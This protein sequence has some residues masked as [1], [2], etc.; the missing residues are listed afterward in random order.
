MLGLLLLIGFIIK[1]FWWIVGAATLVALFFLGRAIL[2]WYDARW[3]IPSQ[4]RSGTRTAGR[5]WLRCYG[6][7]RHAIKHGTTCKRIGIRFTRS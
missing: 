3:T 4:E 6:I 5:C 7:A 2:R 1:F